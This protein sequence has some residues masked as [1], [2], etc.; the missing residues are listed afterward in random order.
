VAQLPAKY[1]RSIG[2]MWRSYAA[3][4]W[5]DLWAC[6][7]LF[8]VWRLSRERVDTHYLSPGDSRRSKLD[9]TLTL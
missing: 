9:S 1:K 6:S 7:L 8:S 3:A 5:R 4:C 2:Y